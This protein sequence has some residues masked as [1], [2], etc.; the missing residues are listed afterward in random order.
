M[1]NYEYPQKSKKKKKIQTQALKK[2]MSWQMQI[3]R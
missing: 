2:K 3:K 1:T